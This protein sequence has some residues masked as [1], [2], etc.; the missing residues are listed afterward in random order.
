MSR[1]EI[2]LVR[3]SPA[4][5]EK[6]ADYRAE[7]PAGRM[8][9][10]L[11]PDAIPGL[12]RLEEF[13]SVAQWLRHCESME[14]KIDWFLSVRGADERVVG[15][16]V[17]RR[18]LEYDDDDPE[19]CSH[20][21]YS[22]RPNERRKGYAREQ[23]RLVLEKAKEAGLPSVRLICRAENTGSVKTILANGGVWLDTI[24][25]EESGL[26]VNRYDIPLCGERED[27]TC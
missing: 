6:I 19:F 1:Q 16:A 23:L 24:H 3:V 9:V 14:G 5:A 17:L 25:G 11:N 7:F 18:R 22:I 12:D 4:Y 13:D 27:T 10:T 26:N 2:R 20:I 21:G 15:A 8:R